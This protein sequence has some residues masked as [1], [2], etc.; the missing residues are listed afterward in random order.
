MEKSSH[1]FSI[2]LSLIQQKP[3]DLGT[4]KRMPTGED[5]EHAP[6][7]FWSSLN[8]G[9]PFLSKRA[10]F[11]LNPS[12]T[13][14][15][16]HAI[17]LKRRSL[18]HF[19]ERMFKSLEK[20]MNLLSLDKEVFGDRKFGIYRGRKCGFLYVQRKLM[21]LD[22]NC[23]LMRCKE[24]LILWSFTITFGPFYKTPKIIWLTIIYKDGFL[25]CVSKILRRW[26]TV[27]D[28]IVLH[29]IKALS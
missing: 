9:I 5:K 21:Y 18:C 25:D 11:R 24:G 3:P 1:C 4:S 14:W 28:Y 17:N 29:W 7:F 15:W 8:R 2:I 26:L 19:L 10:Q 22:R 16:D 13:W 6:L 12:F 23:G 27:W 20:K